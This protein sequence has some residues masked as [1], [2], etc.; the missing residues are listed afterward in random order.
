MKY[1]STMILALGVTLSALFHGCKSDLDVLA[2]YKEIT[3]VYGL[4]DRTDDTLWLKINKAFL[5]DG[6]ALEFAQIPDSNEYANEQFSGV[7]EQLD[8]QGA[9]LNTYP[10]QN[11]IVNRPV[12]IFN[13]P[14]HKMYY[15][16][17]GAG[18]NDDFRYRLKA[19]AKGNVIE[20]S[21]P[22]VNDFSIYNPTQ[23]PN[24]LINFKTSGGYVPYEVKWDVARNGKRYEVSYRFHYDE[25]RT[26]NSVQSKSFTTTI[27]TLISSGPVGEQVSVSL[28][29]E[30]FYQG[31]A[32][33]VQPDPNVV[34]RVFQGIDLLWAVAGPDLHTYLQLASPISGIVE[35]RPDYTN[36]SGGYG[37]FSSRL[38][39]VAPAGGDSYLT[40]KRLN[41]LSTIELIQGQY[42]G[43]LQ[44]CIPGELNC[45]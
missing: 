19:T 25:I 39:K 41:D 13:G 17:A 29:G 4:L 6:N 21:T 42:T 11:T 33:N 12:G 1:R 23:N 45:P 26:D 27:G 30:L 22:L 18:L 38:F 24:T 43:N 7:I 3:V 15:I 2:P 32:N 10:I 44:F 40:R 35:E 36:I 20:A 14:Q 28:N 5:G 8:D 34:K 16:L 9:V 31:V 37:L